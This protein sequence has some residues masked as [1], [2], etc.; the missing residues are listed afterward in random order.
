M[1]ALRCCGEGQQDVRLAMD[2]GLSLG[3]QP[4]LSLGP[5]LEASRVLACRVVVQVSCVLAAQGR[6]RNQASY[7]CMHT[8]CKPAMSLPRSR[9]LST[10]D[11]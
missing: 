2:R 10:G 3:R 6:F 5:G 4:V 8:M 1:D 9:R 11:K 7:F